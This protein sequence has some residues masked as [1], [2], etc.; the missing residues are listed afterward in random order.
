MLKIGFMLP[1]GFQ[2]MGLAASTAFELANT[3]ARERL[4]DIAF[5]SEDGGIVGNSFGAS[6]ATQ[7][8]ARRKLD[9]LIVVGLLAPAPTSPGFLRQLRNA[10]KHARRTASVCTGT[11]ILGEAGLLDG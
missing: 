7:T 2:I 3:T 8:L 6:V 4:Y 5:F 10:A 1:Q 11:F 9:T